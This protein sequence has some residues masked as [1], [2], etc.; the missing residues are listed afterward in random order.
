M[1]RSAL[2][3]AMEPG[4]LFGDGWVGKA[5]VAGVIVLWMISFVLASRLKK[6]TAARGVLNQLRF[7]FF[8]ALIYLLIV[9]TFWRPASDT[10]PLKIAKTA[11]AAAAVV[12]GMGILNL[13]L[14][15]PVLRRWLGRDVPG[16]LIDVVRYLLI[17]VAVAIVLQTVWKEDVTPLIGALGV[18]GI[19][20][21]L[22]LQETLSNFFGGLAI[23]AERPFSIGDWIR[24]GEGREGQVEHVTWRAVKIRT[25]DNEYII[26]P[27][28]MVAK[29]KVVNFNLPTR[30]QARRVTIG[31]GYGN[32]PDQVKRAIRQVLADVPGVL[33]E[34]A[35]SIFTVSY[36]DFAIN[37]E[38]KFFIEDFAA[39]RAIEDAVMSRLWYAFRR[40]GIDIPF[41]I[42]HLYHH[43][44]E[45]APAAG[46]GRP[47]QAD[48][49]A[50]GL[51]DIE[52]ALA[53]VPILAEL[54]S[55]ER[56][57]LSRDA[58]LH[59]YGGGERVIRQGEPGE[60]LYAIAAGAARVAVRGENGGEHEVAL[61]QS[62]DVFGE[63]SLLTGEPRSAT[64]YSQGELRVVEVRKAALAPLLVANPG[65]AARMAE[66]VVLRREGLDRARETA[67]A[68]ARRSEVNAEARALLGRIRT[69]FGLRA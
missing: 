18:G 1:A 50:A 23:L 53:A 31:A 37:Y 48:R 12:L 36:G 39:H 32:P 40:Q 57:A 67:L 55:E 20:I 27:N 26:Y 43:Q 58:L 61:L 35:P 44:A 52:R 6:A 9:I 46:D 54:S 16:L 49:V 47:G 45:E 11:L 22:A 34:P 65:L 14:A 5:A 62:G 8:P 66:V 17:V 56:Q 25:T 13:F 7:L 63:M 19:V 41:P 24:V 51:A 42:R 10:T 59:D 68:A 15:P 21:G 29:E 30:V 33:T 64:V 60:A 2:L 4:T 28:S 69:F 3:E 38:I